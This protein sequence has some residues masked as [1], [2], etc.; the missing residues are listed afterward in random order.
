MAKKGHKSARGDNLD[1]DLMTHQNP[2]SVAIGNAGMNAKGDI[3]GRGGVIVRKVEDIPSNQLAQP[4]SAYN[5]QNPKSMK[6]VSLKGNV[7]ETFDGNNTPIVDQ[8][9]VVAQEEK[10]TSKRKLLDSE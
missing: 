2:N 4:D 7:D 1:F 10:T 3:L 6:M 8:K 9:K 5:V